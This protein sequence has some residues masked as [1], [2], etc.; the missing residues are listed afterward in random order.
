[1]SNLPARARILLE[2]QSI[3]RIFRRATHLD[4]LDETVADLAQ[5]LVIQSCGWLEQAAYELA[6][7]H[8]RN[9]VAGPV[10]SFALSHL[11]KTHNAWTDHLLDLVGRFDLGWQLRL[12]GFIT[13]ERKEAVNS[14]MG[15]RTKIAHGDART[16]RASLGRVRQYFDSCVEVVD[17]LAE[18]LDPLPDP[19]AVVSR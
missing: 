2:R 17:E 10:L 5:L 6:R 1:M 12:D 9:H 18:I 7:E 8:C 16:G 15:L 11:E 4:P 14:L 13:P 19:S 3:E